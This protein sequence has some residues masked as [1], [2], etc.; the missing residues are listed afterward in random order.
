MIRETA[1]AYLGLEAPTQEE[2]DAWHS[3][4]LALRMPDYDD[5][6]TDWSDAC[7]R[8]FFLFLYDSSFWDGARYCTTELASAWRA[9]FGRVD[10]VLL[11]QGYPRI[12]FDRRTQFDFYRQLPG[13]L[14]RVRAEVCDVFRASGIRVFVDWNPWADGSPA[15]LAEIVHALGADG[16]M[17]DTLTSAEG[18]LA[19]AVPGVV[20]APELRMRAEDLPRHRQSWAQWID[21]G[22][23]PS[24]PKNRWRM[25][26]HRQFVIRRWD[27]SRRADIVWSVFNGVGMLLWDNVF[28]SWNPYSREDRKLLAATGAVLDAY[29]DVMTRGEWKPLV[30]TG[31]RG[32]DCNEWT[33]GDRTVLTL[34]N[35][36]SEPIEWTAR[37]GAWT[38]LLGPRRDRA[39]VEAAGVQLLVRDANATSVLAA[40]ESAARAADVDLPGYDERAPA[41]RRTPVAAARRAPNGMIALPGGDFEMR[42][43]HTRRECGCW[44]HPWGSP[45]EE[46][47]EHVVRV[48]LAPFAIRAS[49]V[50]RAEY[51]AF[52][53]ASGWAPADPER[54]LAAGGGDDFPVTHVSLADARAFA[55]FHG[56]RLPTEA[57]W[58]WAAEGAGLGHAYPWGND[59]RTFP[60]RP[61]P[62]R[63][64]ATATPQGVTGLSG[65]A[66]ELTESEHTDGH[67][68]FV[69]LRGGVWLPP[70]AS[71][72]LPAR[73]ARP[74]QSH[75]K[76]ILLA[77]GLDRSETVSFRTV[78]D[79]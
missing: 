57:E 76:Y 27:A 59:A 20:L 17:L 9:R 6:A 79:L 25:P 47:I 68:R 61:R 66:W 41:P 33:R 42:I 36:T 15:E 22:D 69:M 53:R 50:T 39:I 10:S 67:T 28:G 31:I 5:G 77:D 56:E 21:V 44:D 75:A 63:D 70:G 55:A 74:N 62:A 4:M 24:I 40:V 73:G 49:A 52:V 7:F 51:D 64:P 34:R 14:A 3:E 29:G 1:D 65:N 54:L 32:L 12:G 71:E 16:V 13:G 18:D 60:P 45:Y 48:R 46:E 78:V 38:S 26:R 30:P 43:R 2:W 72:W 11:W 8:Q 58:Q 37:G 19:R 35:R 23:G